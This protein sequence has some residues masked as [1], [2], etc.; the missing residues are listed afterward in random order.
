[1]RSRPNSR[2][3]RATVKAKAEDTTKTV[4]NADSAVMAV[5]TCP[6]IQRTSSSAPAARA[7]R[8]SPWSTRPVPSTARPAAEATAAT[9]LGAGCG[10]SSRRAMT[11]T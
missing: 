6:P 1:M 11:R 5:T 10:S 4:T 8:S 3:R 2:R 7:S 9:V